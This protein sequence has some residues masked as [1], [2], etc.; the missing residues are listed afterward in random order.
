[1]GPHS[2]ERGNKSEGCD[3]IPPLSSFERGNRIQRAASMG[4]HSFERGNCPKPHAT[5]SIRDA[6]IMELQW[7]LTLSSEETWDTIHRCFNG[8]SLFRA[9]KL[10]VP[11]CFNGAS[12]FRARK[13]PSAGMQSFK[14]IFNGASLFRARKPGFPSLI[15]TQHHGASMGPHSFERGNTGAARTRHQRAVEGLQW[16]LTLS[17]EETRRVLLQ[18]LRSGVA[19]QASMGPHSFERGNY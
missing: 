13:R 9:R 2:F 18:W 6:C 1:M 10:I 14:Y 19:E 8:A 7:G 3:P 16:G 11:A 17:S 4:P 15:H 5:A 12:L